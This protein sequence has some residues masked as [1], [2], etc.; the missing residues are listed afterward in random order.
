MLG[1]GRFLFRFASELL[2]ITRIVWSI[3]GQSGSFCD[4]VGVTP[5][6]LWDLV[7]SF[8]DL[9]AFCVI[10]LERCGLFE[11][12]LGLSAIA[13]GVTPGLL[14]GLGNFSFAFTSGLGDIPRVLWSVRCHSRPFRGRFQVT[15]GL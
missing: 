2:A 13:F 6:L 14:M 4:R 12:T 9:L 15:P 10:F 1:L 3:R 7:G 11:V 8:S 5:G